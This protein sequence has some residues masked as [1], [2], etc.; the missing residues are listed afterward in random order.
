MGERWMAVLQAADLPHILA[1]AFFVLSI[2]SSTG[3]VERIFST[4][5]NKWTDVWNICSVALIDT[6]N[7]EKS[8]LEFY[9]AA[10]EDKL[11]AAARNPKS[12][13]GK[14]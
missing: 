8:C 2:P 7:Y 4:V 9:S 3:Y 12:T 10:P 11:L 14:T 6:M 1:V 5:R 13:S